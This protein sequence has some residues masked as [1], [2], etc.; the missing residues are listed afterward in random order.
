MLK[1]KSAGILLII[2][3]VWSL[4]TVYFYSQHQR[5][6]WTV[7]VPGWESLDGQGMQVKE[8][9]FYDW[10]SKKAEFRTRYMLIHS[11]I[12]CVNILPQELGRL[13]YQTAGYLLSLYHD[14][15]L[16]CDGY[17]IE[18]KGYSLKER[19]AE[20]WEEG[21]ATIF[22]NGRSI[23]DRGRG[24]ETSENS[25]LINF[26]VRGTLYSYISDIETIHLQWELEE[27]TYFVQEIPVKKLGV[28]K[29]LLTFFDYPYPKTWDTA[30]VTTTFVRGFAL[31]EAKI[32]DFLSEK[33][34]DFPWQ[35]LMWMKSSLEHRISYSFPSYVGEYKGFQNVFTVTLEYWLDDKPPDIDAY[36]T[37][38]L[39]EEG[40]RWCIVDVG[41][42]KKPIGN[43]QGWGK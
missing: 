43:L 20:A 21:N 42:L 5:N 6:V 2:I 3:A 24:R 27:G 32:K 22:V 39:I 8:V 19:F 37:F 23:G 1:R 11:I 13:V 17:R 34:R 41:D 35:R 7:E 10:D 9:V 18:L 40:N 31:G 28:Q 16:R 12:K 33:V 4:V 36:Q 38:Y 14:P 26:Y 29:Q 25:N 30:R 15:Y